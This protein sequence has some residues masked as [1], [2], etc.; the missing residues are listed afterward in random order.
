MLAA[1][2]EAISPTLVSDQCPLA[3]LLIIFL[4]LPSPPPTSPGPSQ[5][6]QGAFSPRKHPIRRSTHIPKEFS[7]L[8]SSHTLGT[9]SVPREH[10]PHG[11]FL[12]TPL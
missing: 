11:L 7:V 12:I 1:G 2:G 10:G 9:T 8:G 3:L 5:S 6:L 4:C